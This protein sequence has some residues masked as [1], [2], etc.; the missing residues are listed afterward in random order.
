MEAAAA[1]ARRE[2]APPLLLACALELH[3][4]NVPFALVE[5][6]DDGKNKLFII[7]GD[8]S[9]GGDLVV[10]GISPSLSVSHFLSL[11][12]DVWL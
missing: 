9:G 2:S 1:G 3:K 12:F 11:S 6:Q 4:A 8:G 7:L 5:A 10:T